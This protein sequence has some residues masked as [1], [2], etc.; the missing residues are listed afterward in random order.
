[1]SPNVF[2]Y[3]QTNVIG[4]MTGFNKETN[5]DIPN[6]PRPLIE[7]IKTSSSR[8]KKVVPKDDDENIPLGRN[9]PTTGLNQE[10][11]ILDSPRHLIDLIERNIVPKDEDESIPLGITR[12][13]TGWMMF[14]FTIFVILYLI[15]AI[16]VLAA[17]HD[18][19]DSLAVMQRDN[20]PAML[21]IL[22]STG[23]ILT[24]FLFKSISYPFI[25]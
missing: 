25:N 23:F 14:P 5:I 20:F 12:S 9:P 24:I 7:L 1:M 13:T 15:I 18:I 16:A 2:P 19:P 22:C 21:A 3:L 10:G 6:S 4:H 17:Y 11:N 8:S